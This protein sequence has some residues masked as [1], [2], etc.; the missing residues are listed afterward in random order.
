MSRKWFDDKVPNN[1]KITSEN[2]LKFLLKTVENYIE[3]FNTTN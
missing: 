2:K 1:D 3:K